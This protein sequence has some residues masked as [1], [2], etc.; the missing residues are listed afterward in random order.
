MSSNKKTI[1]VD[2]LRHGQPE[3]GDVLRGRID[4]PLSETGWQ[5]MK[6]VTALQEEFPFDESGPVWTDLIT[7]PLQRC[8]QFAE[9]VSQQTEL[10]LAIDEAW[11]E[12]DYGKWDGMLLSDWRKE[13][14][15]QFREFR[16]DL[17]KLAP[18][19]GEDY[20]SFKDRILGAWDAIAAKPDGSHVLLV[21]HG[22]V[23]R[24]VLPTVL[25][26]PLNRSFPLHIPFACLSRISLVV[27]D[28]K[29]SAS[30]LSH[31][32]TIK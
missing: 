1:I 5:Q 24:V 26:M 25:G 3:G 8:R 11:Q 22:G 28:D 19:E 6:S 13:A 20:L 16:K 23:M 32:A 12:I 14:A 29:V 15:Y 17:S 27:D 30:L 18:P 7:S 2:L 9:F 21:T 4:H 10:T 31:N